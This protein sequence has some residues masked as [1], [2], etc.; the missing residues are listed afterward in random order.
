LIYGEN[1]MGYN[2]SGHIAKL[3]MKRRRR[4]EQRLARKAAAAAAPKAGEKAAS[5]G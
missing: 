5:R 3:R 1:D 2:R 4:E